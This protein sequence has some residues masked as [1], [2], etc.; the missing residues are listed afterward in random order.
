MR[1]SLASNP[2]KMADMADAPMPDAAMPDK[3]RRAFGP[4]PKFA[5]AIS[6]SF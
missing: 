5:V 6:K 2:T 1:F 3:D 4:H